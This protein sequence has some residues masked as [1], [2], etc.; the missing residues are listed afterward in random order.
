MR[1]CLLMSNKGQNLQALQL[2]ERLIQQDGDEEDRT[3]ER[4]RE[5]LSRTDRARKKSAGVA[6]RSDVR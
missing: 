5:T 1:S 3:T 2:M 6:M 4:K